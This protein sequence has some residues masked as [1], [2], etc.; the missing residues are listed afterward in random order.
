MST[1]DSGRLIPINIS[2]PILNYKE[3]VHIRQ[4]VSNL[5]KGFHILSLILNDAMNFD[6][7]SYTATIEHAN[8]FAFSIFK[9]NNG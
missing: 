6:E 9:I 3:D 2:S 1:Q 5:I 4:G 8:L 7:I